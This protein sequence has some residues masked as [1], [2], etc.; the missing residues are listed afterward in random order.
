MTILWIPEV[1]K[2]ST[3]SNIIQGNVKSG[4][5]TY[6]LLPSSHV[7]S[8]LQ[9]WG[10]RESWRWSF[11][12]RGLLEIPTYY[13]RRKRKENR[14]IKKRKLRRKKSGGGVAGGK[15]Q[16]LEA[17]K[18]QKWVSET[19]NLTRC[20]KAMEEREEAKPDKRAASRKKE[21][22]DDELQMWRSRLCWKPAINRSIKQWYHLGQSTRSPG[23]CRVTHFHSVYLC[24]ENL[25]RRC[26]AW[27]LQLKSMF[28][29]L[30]NG[31]IVYC[32]V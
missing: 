20:I 22:W 13:L 14:E 21:R 32:G 23:L 25:K 28:K 6:G 9:P 24:T 29:S 17:S 19:L 27:L 10:R 2:T 11:G 1:M 26:T 30:N 5:V 8:L 12:L 18:I 4:S 15:K 7:N 3:H 31:S 16:T